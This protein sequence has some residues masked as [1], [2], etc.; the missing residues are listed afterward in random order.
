MSNDNAGENPARRN[1]GVVMAFADN[2]IASIEGWLYFMSPG[3]R[4][5]R[6]C[7]RVGWRLATK[8]VRLCADGR[9]EG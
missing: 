1:V 3:D 9:Y 5:L 6:P 8:R 2:Q 4:L 7:K